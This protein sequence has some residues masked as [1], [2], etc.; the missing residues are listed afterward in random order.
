M[1]NKPLPVYEVEFISL[2]SYEVDYIPIERRMGE[3]RINPNGGLPEGVA[4]DRR[5][6]DRRHGSHT[7]T[8]AANF[9][10]A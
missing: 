9:Q 1:A 10:K 6:N 2:P 5:K 7:G 3:R 8:Q 4:E